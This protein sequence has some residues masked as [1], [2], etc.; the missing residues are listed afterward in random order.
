MDVKIRLR[1]QKSMTNKESHAELTLRVTCG[2]TYP[3]S[4]P[5]FEVLNNKGVPTS[6]TDQLI[7][8]IN[9]MAENLKGEVRLIFHL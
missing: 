3:D 5:S 4:V 1:P 9:K 2:P 6:A 7:V 8:E